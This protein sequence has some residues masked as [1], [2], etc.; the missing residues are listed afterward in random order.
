MAA[1]HVPCPQCLA[2][3]RVRPE[4]ASDQP[5]CGRCKTLLFSAHPV[6]LDD[7]NFQRY[8]DSSELPVVVDFWATWCPPC[9]AMAP[10][11]EAAA[12]ESLGQ[13]VFAK[14]DTD[15][16]RQTAARFR[17]QSIPTMIVFR[18]GQEVARQSGALSKAQIMSWL[19]PQRATSAA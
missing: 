2:V 9:R 1:V 13:V 7:T 12:R 10:Q 11:F 17:I 3:N 5:K 4:R 6:T 15:A 18:R 8:V 16:A 14:L 19:A